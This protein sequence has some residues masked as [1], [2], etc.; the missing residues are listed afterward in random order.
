MW[1]LLFSPIYDHIELT[2]WFNWLYEDLSSLGLIYK[3]R[4]QALSVIKTTSISLYGNDKIKFVV[5]PLDMRVNINN[6]K[7][8]WTNRGF[9]KDYKVYFTNHLYSTIEELNCEHIKEIK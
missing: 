4:A 8:A 5:F 7:F 2:N 6:V 3:T 9:L 1:A